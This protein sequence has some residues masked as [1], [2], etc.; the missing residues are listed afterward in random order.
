M[1]FV[2]NNL[3]LSRWK[4]RFEVNFIVIWSIELLQDCAWVVTRAINHLRRLNPKLPNLRPLLDRHLGKLHSVVFFGCGALLLNTAALVLLLITTIAACFIE[5]AWG[6]LDCHE[7][8]RA[9][10][11]SLVADG[12]WGLI[13]ARCHRQNLLLLQLRVLHLWPGVD[14]GSRRLV[15]DGLT[16][17]IKFGSLRWW[18]HQ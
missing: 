4:V 15:N 14:L 11:L 9:D 2:L 1:S 6:A 7:L 17:V 16:T 3:P 10:F 12:R 5:W 13:G 8:R 18:A